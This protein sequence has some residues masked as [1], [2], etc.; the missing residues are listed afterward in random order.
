[1]IDHKFNPYDLLEKLA[2]QQRDQAIQMENLVKGLFEQKDF[3]EKLIDA[4]NYNVD[5]IK[6]LLTSNKELH[7]R[8][9]LLEIARM[10]ETSKDNQNG[11][12]RQL[13]NQTTDV[14]R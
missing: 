9:T 8:I 7:D 3:I 2:R 4:N 12:T 1:M 5:L 13:S 6:Q 14:G 10:Y 11:T